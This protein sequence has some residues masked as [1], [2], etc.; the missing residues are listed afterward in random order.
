MKK[1]QGFTLVE[2][3]VVAVI[4]AILAAVSIAMLSNTKREAIM[5][6]GYAG[7][8]TLKRRL[9]FTGWSTESTPRTRPLL[10]SQNTT[11]R[12]PCRGPI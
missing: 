4:V 6:E 1:K 11:M 10:P 7:L 3:M 2:L 12:R 9:N 5:T 8:D